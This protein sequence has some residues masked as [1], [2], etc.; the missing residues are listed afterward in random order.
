MASATKYRP[1]GR[2]QLWIPSADNMMEHGI[3]HSPYLQNPNYHG[4]NAHNAHARRQIGQGFTPIYPLVHTSY[5]FA[6]YTMDT[7]AIYD[8]HPTHDQ[9]WQLQ[10]LAYNGTH[11]SREPGKSDLPADQNLHF[12]RK[13]AHAY[14]PEYMTTSLSMGVMQQQTHFLKPY[15]V[16]NSTVYVAHFAHNNTYHGENVGYNGTYTHNE[17]EDDMGYGNNNSEMTM[18]SKYRR[19]R[20]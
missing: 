19:E 2:T 16:G 3:V 10:G 12:N 17:C 9:T 14:P 11:I 7:S 20:Y 15:N 13:N 6:P 8:A 1:S 18:G 5:P 4:N